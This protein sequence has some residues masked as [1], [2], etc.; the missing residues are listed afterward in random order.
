MLLE[1]FRQAINTVCCGLPSLRYRTEEMSVFR[2]SAG[3]SGDF[4]LMESE[5]QYQ[6]L[7]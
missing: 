7:N 6:T 2:L 3:L 4:W 5:A 1:Y